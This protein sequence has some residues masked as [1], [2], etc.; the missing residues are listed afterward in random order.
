MVRM[1]LFDFSVDIHRC[2]PVRSASYRAEDDEGSDSEGDPFA[3]FNDHEES[4]EEMD[5][6]KDDSEKDCD[7]EDSGGVEYDDGFEKGDNANVKTD[8][9][10]AASQNAQKYIPPALRRCYEEE[11]K[12]K[13]VQAEKEVVDNAEELDPQVLRRTRGLLNRVAE[14]NVKVVSKLVRLL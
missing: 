11:K 12:R 14:A 13:K 9:V 8:K 5:D 3:D 6:D 2:A 4:G 1:R 7:S 10:Y